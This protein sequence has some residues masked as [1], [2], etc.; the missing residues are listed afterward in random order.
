[1]I[2][3]PIMPVM[4]AKM[5]PC[6]DLLGLQMRA[7]GFGVGEIMP[8]QAAFL[9]PLVK[10]KTATC[11]DQG[12]SYENDNVHTQQDGGDV[13]SRQVDWAKTDPNAAPDAR[14]ELLL[15]PAAC[16]RTEHVRMIT[17]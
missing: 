14:T 10:R 11:D 6:A 2:A 13:V 1:M 15:A 16:H 8:Q 9:A 3:E 12:K 5:I 7:D 17:C 4:R